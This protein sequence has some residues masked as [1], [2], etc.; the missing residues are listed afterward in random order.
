MIFDY[1]NLGF[2]SVATEAVERLLAQARGARHGRER[3]RDRAAWRLGRRLGDAV[4]AEI[5]AK[6]E[7]GTHT[8][9]LAA[10]Y[11]VSKSGVVDLLR[12]RGIRLRY[13]TMTPREVESAV[14]A[15]SRGMSLSQLAAESPFS[16]ETIRK[17]LI[18]AGVAMRPARR[19]SAT[20]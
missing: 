1:S 15:Y 3:A 10:E 18:R 13:R 19:T 6:Y 9:D 2:T 17:A 11:G 16:Q 4:V 7:A 5:V 20:G 8:T 14:A 12:Q